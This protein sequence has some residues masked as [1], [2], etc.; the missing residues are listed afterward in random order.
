[1]TAQELCNALKVVLK[2]YGTAPLK[3]AQIHVLDQLK[4][5]PKKTVVIIRPTTLHETPQG[6]GDYDTSFHDNITLEIEG[7]IRH[8]DTGA[9]ITKAFALEQQ[10][11][12]IISTNRNI[13]A[14]GDTAIY[15]EVTGSGIQFAPRTENDKHDYRIVTVT[16]EW[17]YPRESVA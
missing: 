17:Q 15:A 2:A 6:T 5:D 11:R 13:S 1:M 8:A 9:N 14:G 4:Y 10:I 16:S 3:G 7:T 12:F